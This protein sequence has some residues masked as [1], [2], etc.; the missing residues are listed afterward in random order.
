[1]IRLQ[2]RYL[3]QHAAVLRAIALFVA[4]ALIGIGAW[5]FQDRWPTEL[6]RLV[7]LEVAAEAHELAVA[8]DGHEHGHD[9]GGHAHDHEH[10][11]HDHEHAGHD[12]ANSLELSPQARKNIGLETTAIELQPF[13]RRVTMPAIVIGRPGR[14]E[15]EVTAPLGGRITRV[16][17]VGG[18]AVEPGQLLFDL[19]LTHEELVNAQSN[20][21]RTAGE[22]EVVAREI[23][24]LQ[25]IQASGAIAGKTLLERQ[26]E[27][28]KLMAVFNAQRQS[29]LLHGLTEEQVDG[30]L[31][32]RT[33]LRDITVVT[34]EHP[35]HS[36]PEFGD[37]PFVVRDLTVKQGQYVD[38][39]APL[40]QLADYADLYLQGRGFEQDADELLRAAQQ[41][42]EII[43]TREDNNSNAEVIDGLKIAYVDNDVDPDSR[44]LYFYIPLTNAIVLENRSPEG[45]RF[46]TW[47]YK[48]GQRMQVHVP[49]QRWENRIVLPIE[50]VAQ[51]G[52]EHY[53]FQ[54]NGDHFD[55]IAVHVEYQDRFSVVIANDGSL[56]PGDV[57]AIK[58]AQ[59]LQMA[60]KNK[61]GGGVDPHAG[62]NH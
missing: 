58:A 18:E 56:S 27:Q 37:H 62:H 47:R 45:H 49:V 12:E 1:M 34:P 7:G 60:L 19:R 53:V 50:A 54:Q 8:D 42:W 17:P 4:V 61:A 35:E 16:Y 44:A 57:V 31:Q 41:G 32:T 21:L 25:S 40:C 52:I 51:D 9:H 33:L 48:P 11:G 3:Q 10:A 6:K 39:G 20:F 5:W 38:A 23:E 26:Y 22:L 43:A 13:V 14:T 59:Q 55:R 46:V 24:R 15:V 30:I 36:H 29:L 28:Q 2:V